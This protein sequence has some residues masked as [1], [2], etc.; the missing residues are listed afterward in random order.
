MSKSIYNDGCISLNN[1]GKIFSSEIR[2]A[3]I[4]IINKWIDDGYSPAEIMCFMSQ[5]SNLPTTIAAL[6][7]RNK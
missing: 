4:P 1:E 6:A 2:N 5:V 7:K 3:I